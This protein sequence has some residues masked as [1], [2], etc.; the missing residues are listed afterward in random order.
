MGLAR[1]VAKEKGTGK[2]NLSVISDSIQAISV[3]LQ[4]PAASA[5]LPS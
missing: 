5:I 4:M 3:W 1:V 2:R